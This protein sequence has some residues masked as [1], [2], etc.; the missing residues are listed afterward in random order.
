MLVSREYRNNLGYQ[1]DIDRPK[2]IFAWEIDRFNKNRYHYDGYNTYMSFS[3]GREDGLQYGGGTCG[4]GKDCDCKPIQ[5]GKGVDPVTIGKTLEMLYTGAKLAPKIYASEPA[6]VIKNT[7]GKFMNSNPN[8]RPGFAGEKHLISKKGLTY[9]YCGPGTNLSA[10]LERGDPGLDK[11]GLDLVCKAHDIEYRDANSWDQVRKADERFI[12]R[13]DQTSIGKASKKVIKGM[14]K[15][16]MIGEDLGLV[17]P[18]NFTQFPNIQDSLPPKIEESQPSTNISGQ[19]N[20]FTKN[21][22]PARKLKNKMKKYRSRRNMNK[23][24]DLASKAV[25]RHM[26]K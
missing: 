10:R 7:Y 19:G 2:P 24:L 17:K 5:S 22:D 25:V 21:R 6:T 9:N 16:K 15:A 8:W 23:I 1:I 13:V 20:L 4:K 12:K 11:E 14:F 26:R 18:S 3:R